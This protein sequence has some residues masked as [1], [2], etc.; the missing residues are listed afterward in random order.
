MSIL[1]YHNSVPASNRVA[2]ALARRDRQA[3]LVANLRSVCYL[4][5][6]EAYDTSGLHNRCEL[7]RLVQ[8]ADNV[9]RRLANTKPEKTN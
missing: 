6:H 3:K 7:V 1:S 2:R 8:S 4:A 9:L 5:S